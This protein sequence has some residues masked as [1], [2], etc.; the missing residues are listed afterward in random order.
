MTSACLIETLQN[1]V[2][3]NVSA[4]VVDRAGS[5]RAVQPFG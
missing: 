5:V 3:H 1:A 4:T 2:R